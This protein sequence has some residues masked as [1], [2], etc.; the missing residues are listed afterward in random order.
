MLHCI[1]CLR[2]WGKISA[3]RDDPSL[4]SRGAGSHH[5][6]SMELVRPL[7]EA[8]KIGKCSKC[9]ALLLEED[10]KD[11]RLWHSWIKEWSSHNP[12]FIPLPDMELIR[13]EL[14][15]FLASSE[16][17]LESLGETASSVP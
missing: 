9:S 14:R 3:E 2:V 15:E 4:G 10:I 8:M 16:D 13:S 17:Q 12:Q 1:G 6:G 7:E 11:H 5:C